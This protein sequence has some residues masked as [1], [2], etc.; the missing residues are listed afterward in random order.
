MEIDDA[1][2]ILPDIRLSGNANHLEAVSP[3]LL[4]CSGILHLLVISGICYCRALHASHLVTKT[5]LCFVPLYMSCLHVIAYI[6]IY[7]LLVHLAC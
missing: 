2:S 6:Y 7:Y 4:E 3:L 1:Y 5:D